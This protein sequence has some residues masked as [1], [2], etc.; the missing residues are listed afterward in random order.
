MAE[1]SPIQQEIP[2]N[3]QEQPQIPE[4]VQFLQE[5]VKSKNI[6]EML[7]DAEISIIGSTAKREYQLDYDSRREWRKDI[8][9]AMDIA[10]QVKQP[11]TFPWKDASN[12]KYPLLTTASIQFAARA[13]PA[14]VNNAS[15][16]K[17]KIVG[18]DAGVPQVDERGQPIPDPQS[19]DPETGEPTAPLWEKPP[20]AKRQR[21]D[22]VARHMSWQLTDEMEEWEAD[23][24]RLMHVLPI[25]G[26]A[27]RK[28]WFDPI[29][30]RNCSKL[31]MPQDLVI[32]YDAKSM[33]DAPRMTYEFQLYPHQV[34]ERVREG[35]YLDQP[36]GGSENGDD[37]GPMDF[38]EQHRLLDLDEDGY[39]EPYIVTLHKKTGY[40]M[41][42]V[43]RF[44]GDSL[45]L[46]DA[47]EVK[48]ITPHVYF[49]LYGF[50]P[51]PESAIYFL[52]FGKLLGPINESVN[53]ALNQMFDSAT[54][55][56]TGGGFI[57]NGIRIPKGS[58]RFRPGEYKVVAS[59]GQKLADSIFKMDHSGPSPVL[60]QLL[61]L[62]IDAGK[63]ISSVQDVMMGDTGNTEQTA[64]TTLAL[65]EQGMK[66]FSAIFKRIHR[67]LGK[68]LKVLYDL[69]RR[70]MPEEQYF[71]VLDEMDAVSQSDYQTGDFDIVPI[72]DPAMVT[73]MQRMAKADYLKQF[74]GDQYFN[75]ME[76]R[77]RMM[78]AANVDTDRLL[79][80]PGPPPRDL[81]AEAKFL[82][83]VGE[84]R[85]KKEMQ[86]AEITKLL[87]SAL[88]DVTSSQ[89]GEGAMGVGQ[90]EEVIE[91]INDEYREA[92]GLGSMEES[93]P[94]AGVLPTPG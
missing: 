89:A 24:D 63:E 31:V 38:L 13:Y 50:I 94:N 91:E 93:D 35:L 60:F 85:L 44:D 92:T 56:I 37:D 7:E 20:G 12:V 69:N 79:Q 76:I 25:T 87:T 77:T 48:K 59:G 21:G 39:P 45:F 52:G 22:R 65:I 9:K 43:A 30:G 16:A 18:S 17:C 34:T 42:I 80:E 86:P 23:T 78:D 54:L 8:D 64:T 40:V 67:S 75:Q 66:S 11:K 53:T 61:G 46:N 81:T 2:Q 58:L 51:N 14:I 49:T 57:G 88:K 33:E 29:K 27:F 10:L 84:L 82:K 47:A 6:A 19:V 3:T 72:S 41:R 4:N 55:Q 1:I 83:A 90:A 28:S 15:V 32:N 5:I 68:E 73:D 36:L 74:I 70:F 62:L 26:V 71:N